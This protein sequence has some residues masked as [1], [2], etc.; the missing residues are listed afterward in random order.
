MTD[1]AGN[2]S[3]AVVYENE[4]EI[5]N[6]KTDFVIDQKA[7]EITI[8]YD[9]KD[10]NASNE[11]YFNSNRTMTVTYTETYFNEENVKLSLKKSTDDDEMTLAEWLEA[12]E[13]GI[14]V[15]KD[16]AN[17][18]GNKHIYQ[19]TFG[20]EKTEGEYSVNTAMTDLAGNPSEAVVYENEDEIINTKTDFVIDQ[21]APEIT[22][23][24]DLK[25]ENASNENYFNSNRTMTV[26]YTETY[27]NEENV[28]LSLKKS[29]D[30]DEMTL[31]EWLEADE[32]GITVT[33]DEANSKGNKHIYQVTFG[34]E[35]YDEDYNVITSMT[36]YAENPNEAVKY[37]DEENI[38]KTKTTFTVDQVAPVL[39]VKFYEQYDAE[40]KADNVELDE[41]SRLTI[42][43]GE[44]LYR[45]KGIYVGFQIKE[46]NFSNVAE[47]TIEGLEAKYT[48]D[49][50]IED[51]APIEFDK[52]AVDRKEW[53]YDGET[54]TA[55]QTFHFAVQANYTIGMNYEDL[56]G[57]KAVYRNSDGD[58]ISDTEHPEYQFTVDWTAP[59]G[60]IIIP[61]SDEKPYEFTTGSNE[62][63]ERIWECLSDIIYQIF[64]NKDHTTVTMEGKDETSGVEKIYYYIDDRTTAETT[65]KSLSKTELDAA[66]WKEYSNESKI[67][68][69]P[70]SQAAIYEKIVDKSGNITYFNAEYGV[71]SDNLKPKINLQDMSPTRNGLHY[72]DVTIRVTVEDPKYND[73]GVY[74]GIEKVEYTIK[75]T[76]N[77]VAT[78]SDSVAMS[79]DDE[80]NNERIRT[81]SGTIT[82]DAEKFNSNDVTVTATV[83]DLAGNTETAE[84]DLSI[85]ATAPVIESIQ[86]NTNDASNGKYYNETR[87]AT[88][89]V[90]ERN[91]DPN[92]VRL[93]ITNTD[94]TA[95]Q[96]SSWRVD[97][98]GTSDNNINTCTVTF[99]ADGDYNMN[100]S[101]TDKAGWT[102]NTVTAEEFTIDK[103][104]PTINVSFDNNSVAN[105]KYY[106]AA[107]TATITVNEHNFNG[108]DVQTA[109]TSNTSTPGV[110]GWGGSGNVHTA[111]V[112]FTT[113]GEYS[114]TV[115]Y[116]DLAGN[117]AQVYSVD[118]FVIDLT[119]PEIEIFDI[120]DKSANNGVVAPGV[121]YS[122]TNYDVAGVSI[123]YS[124][125][126][127]PEEAVDGTRT[128]IPNGESIKMAD[129][130]HT[131]AT[132]DVYTMVAQVTDLAGNSEEKQ[133]TFSVN[134]FG[135][136]FIF[137]D[138]TKD[139]L[140]D[141]YNNEE[142]DLVVTEINVDTLT[143]R[144]ITSGHDGSMTDL[145]EGTDYTVRESGS[146]VSWKSYQY[147]ISKEN[148]EKE[149]MY[150]ITID[151]V[152]RATNQVNN[153]IKEANIDFVIDKTAPTVV[154]TGIEDGG[155][156]RSDTRD[157]TVSV[158]DNVA[159]EKVDVYTNDGNKETTEPYDE[160]MIQ[161]QNGELAYTL[162]SSSDWQEIKAV[163]V[164]KAGNVTDTSLTDGSD[165]ERWMSVLVTSNLFVQFYRN[166]PLLI[167]TIVAVAAIGG[168]L[169]FLIL[170]KKRKKD[171]EEQQAA[172]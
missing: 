44:R 165:S 92:Q 3:E 167:G 137:S 143:H 112:P 95:A 46:R 105:G 129:F 134:R 159:M 52:L 91:F 20:A 55:S 81:G 117:A 82:V 171:E 43:G 126:N 51:N 128:A 93:N 163:A 6:T 101:C 16:E 36:D 125:P 29:T 164:D 97:S 133:V 2:P 65:A 19:V 109:I 14:T 33:K 60:K 162:T 57:N 4:D 115:N 161:S 153:K 42:E 89:T 25:D 142:E 64:T 90:R 56:A 67:D 147:T 86:W 103:T 110:N 1:L 170:A 121:R 144:G 70:N 122:D 98:S 66:G 40:N 108:S 37:E 72:D 32:A 135:S 26:T 62:N 123:T 74:S 69:V 76:T 151:S 47:G 107:R 157:I 152:D 63:F 155:Q 50:Y 79:Y 71:V 96:V 18:K 141:Y 5:I 68:I 28:K 120:E 41:E 127:H 12:D 10:E 104:V 77:K 149:G 146:E 58:I 140:D 85:D 73:V 114:F 39:N 119:K 31:A 172:Q 48:T 100:V 53:V 150:S 124:G 17:S 8:A 99:S 145:T 23:A 130:A 61:N 156:Y 83:Y 131:E 13:A 45:Y 113:D 22:I 75:S 80:A 138:A 139:F 54:T 158:A 118:E 49:G 154:I 111:T 148:F 9:L 84:I 102:S 88:I 27:F 160:D 166:T 132:D 21:K 15:T 169:F 24:Y 106:N 34:A 35:G 38:I 11:N 94:G 168:G 116:T 78:E 30:D 7:P 59:T 87:V 136:N